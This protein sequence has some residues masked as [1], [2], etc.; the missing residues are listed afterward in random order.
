VTGFAITPFILSIQ[1]QVT[2]QHANPRTV[3]FSKTTM[4]CLE[5][6]YNIWI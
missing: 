1:A 2:A 6:T 5:D 3:C 4:S